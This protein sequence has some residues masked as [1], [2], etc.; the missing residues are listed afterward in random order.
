MTGGAVKIVGLLVQA[1]DLEALGPD[2][3]EGLQFST[4]FFPAMSGEALDWSRRLTARHGGHPPTMVQAMSYSATLHYLKALQAL[5][6][7]DNAKVAAWLHGHRVDDILTHDAA[8]RP[9]GRVMNDLYVVRVKAPA[10][11]TDP[12]DNLRVLTQLPAD[13]LYPGS[14]E[15]ACPL[16]RHEGAGK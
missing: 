10:E 1:T 2:Q 12:L 3:A 4:A 5:G 6:T 8:V 11:I 13:E 14:A 15:S 16:F 7:D 9:D